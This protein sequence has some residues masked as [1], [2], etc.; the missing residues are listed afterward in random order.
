MLDFD[1]NSLNKQN[2]IEISQELRSKK[3]EKNIL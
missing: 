2:I 1:K 3:R